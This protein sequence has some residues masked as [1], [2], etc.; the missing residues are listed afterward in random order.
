MTVSVGT[1]GDLIARTRRWLNCKGNPIGKKKSAGTHRVK[2][3]EKAHE[4]FVVVFI[5]SY[6]QSANPPPPFL[7]A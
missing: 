7:Y 1:G 2:I 6:K 4:F 3:L 5:G